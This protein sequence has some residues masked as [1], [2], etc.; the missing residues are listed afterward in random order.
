MTIEPDESQRGLPLSPRRSTSRVLI[1]GFAAFTVL[2]GVAEYFGL[3]A[4]R[5][6]VR[7]IN[8]L[9]EYFPFLIVIYALMVAIPF[10]P[11]VTL[12][13]A[14]M[15]LFGAKVAFW[16]WGASVVGM[17][18]AF[19]VGRSV[20]PARIAPLLRR[21]RMED[22]I[23]FLDPDTPMTDRQRLAGLLGSRLW[24]RRLIRWRY[25]AVSL[26]AVAPGNVLLGG[27]GGIALLAG[28]SKSFRLV[29][30]VLA[31]ALP[32]LPFYYAVWSSG[33]DILPGGR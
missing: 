19:T 7:S 12:G 11:G 16:V 10:V 30:F 24:V 18:L 29:P 32:M 20:P 33:L 31:A 1:Y 15:V 5:A 28:L 23:P 25:L 26:V 9:R 13:V 3:P 4:F 6:F 2:M 27:A 21:L 14:I 8:I 22:R 17:L